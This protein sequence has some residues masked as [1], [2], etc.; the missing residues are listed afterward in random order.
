MPHITDDRKAELA[1]YLQPLEEIVPH[2]SGGDITYLICMLVAAYV[3]HG[4]IV[5]PRFEDL[6]DGA[7]VLDCALDSWHADVLRPYEVRKAKTNGNAY[8]R[9]FPHRFFE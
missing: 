4:G 2:C 5:A 8:A 7:G 6:K 9:L 3:T 1:P